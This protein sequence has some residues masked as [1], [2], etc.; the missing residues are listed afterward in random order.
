MTVE[1]TWMGGAEE[2][3]ANCCYLCVGGVGIVIDAGM[4]PKRRDASAL[5]RVEAIGDKPVDYIVIT[6]AHTDHIGGLPYILHR[7]PHAR[8]MMT[9]ATRDIA[10]IVIR[11]SAK[12]LR[13]E[14]GSEFP[15]EALS[16]YRREWLDK[17]WHLFEGYNYGEKIA[18]RPRDG[19]APVY[20]T[21]CD[22]GHILG[23]AG[24]L[25]EAE[26]RSIFHTG[27][28]QF[29][30]HYT[31]AGAS[32]PE[33]HLDMVICESTNGASAPPTWDEERKN[34]AA[35]VNTVSNAG[36]SILVPCF[37]LGKTQEMMTMLHHMMKK[38]EIPLLPLYTGGMGRKI[39]RVYDRYCYSVPRAFPGFEIADIPHQPIQYDALAT[40][41]YLSFPSVVVASSGMM[42]KKTTSFLLA[43][44]WIRRPNFG[45]A[46]PGYVD[47]EEPGAE[48]LAIPKGSSGT[49]AGTRWKVSC[50]VRRFRFSSHAPLSDII[51]YLQKVRPK[52]L[53]AVHGEMEACEKMAAEAKVAIPDT[54]V[55]IPSV[56]KTYSVEL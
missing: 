47:P 22:A 52:T 45:I 38:G 5:P 33:H 15:A 27:D 26:G 49:V 17:L 55:W 13:S 29:S 6:H 16:L 39:S 4:H 53:F 9:L 24:V 3:G 35:F 46:F 12:I 25:I 48:L 50:E 11:N 36:G 1:L 10:E 7:W 14:A 44:E 23:S 32:F 8:L 37:S 41:H 21:F 56:A 31:L 20:L 2:I 51:G 43:K 54:K 18:L 42:S 34:L 19:S 30:R 28:V 40:G